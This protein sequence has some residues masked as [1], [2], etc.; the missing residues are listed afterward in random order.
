MHF[1]DRVKKKKQTLNSILKMG[2]RFKYLPKGY[3]YMLMLSVFCKMLPFNRIVNRNLHIGLSS[4]WNFPIWVSKRKLQPVT[5][6]PES[7]LAHDSL[8]HH[9]AIVLAVWCFPVV[10]VWKRSDKIVERIA[11]R[12]RASHRHPW[13][14]LPQIFYTFNKQER[15]HFFGSLTPSIIQESSHFLDVLPL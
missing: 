1:Q 2:P 13:S 7:S 8:S 4:D 15:S 9:R 11:Y 6:D 3:H 14:V 12:S 5:H 10:S